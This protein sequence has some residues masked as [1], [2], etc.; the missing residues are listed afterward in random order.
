MTGTYKAVAVTEPGKFAIVERPIPRPG[1]GQVLIRIEAC[2]ICHTDAI[3]VG[4]N[5]PGLTLPRV[6]GHEVVGRVEALGANVSG[7]RI[8]QR[9]VG[10][11]FWRPGRHMRTLPAR[12]LCQLSESHCSRPDHGRRLRRGDDRRSPC[13]RF[14]P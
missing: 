3:T 9:R 5:Y 4:G 7:W 12:G 11:G 14:D 6:P 2:G 8:G 1:A 13:P 10:V